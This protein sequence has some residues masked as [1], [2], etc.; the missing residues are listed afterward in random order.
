[1]SLLVAICIDAD[2]QLSAVTF[3]SNDFLQ[4]KASKT[5]AVL[6]GNK[7]YDDAMAAALNESWK[8]TP[9]DFVDAKQFKEKIRDK[10]AS[11]IIPI[12]ISTEYPNQN[13]HFVALINGG[14]KKLGAY[15]YEDMLA[16]AIVNHFGNEPE[17]TDCAP[18]LRN[19]IE[20]LVNSMK[21]VEQNDI[22][23]NSKKIAD[24]LMD[25]YRSQAYK[26]KDRTLLICK[27]SMG[28]KLDENDIT[29]IY[30]YKFEF[31]SRQK[32]ED[33]IKNKDKNYYYLQ[34]A[35]TLNKALFV[36]D[37]VTGEV[38]Y[39]NYQTMGL[40]I[41]KKNIEELIKAINQK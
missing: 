3:K 18:R 4:F 6:T 12:V 11:F 40:N 16:Y 27:E 32:I 28:R 33:A 22:K 31:C 26:I 38:V 35:M 24:Q 41:N 36:F 13:Y 7:E 14:K 9:F 8:I 17:V 30:P 21:L 37:P 39:G 19:M 10:N 1:M 2:A 5:Y 20:S 23:G 34:P 25:Y 29:N 15:G